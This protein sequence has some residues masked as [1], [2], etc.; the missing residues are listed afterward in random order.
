MLAHPFLQDRLYL[1]YGDKRLIEEQYE[2]TVRLIEFIRAQAPDH[3][4]TIGISDHATIAPKP[5]GETATAFYYHHV[6][7]LA[8]FADLLG[9]PDDHDRYISLAG[10]IKKAFIKEFVENG[11]V[12]VQTM[13]AQS[14]ALYYDLLPEDQKV[15]AVAVLEKDIVENNKGHLSTGIFGT[16][17]MFDVFR[18]VDRNDLGYLVTSQK[19][20]PGYG[21]MIEN[22]GTTIWE[23]WRGGGSSYNHPMFGSVSEW[24]YKSLAG[25]CAED[26]AAGFDRFIIK[27]G[28][29]GDIEW[30]N[31]SYHSV[32]GKIV[33]N[34]SL[35]D[36]ILQLDCEIPVNTSARIIIP[37]TDTTMVTESGLPLPDA[38]G[39]VVE[40][41]DGKYL[42]LRAGSGTYHFISP[43]AK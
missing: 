31:S 17:M 10:E 37:A 11:K 15:K 26:D 30:I 20:Y 8:R 34:W 13:G 3:I 32:R 43:V 6:L 16:K 12:G 41:Y 36:G 1:Y 14:F 33:S 24:F 5:K 22:G 2:A 40:D 27:P 38:Q 19:D 21:F 42:G 4:L 35:K 18:M 9:K 7:L 28:V 29:V 25:I 23:S 39:I